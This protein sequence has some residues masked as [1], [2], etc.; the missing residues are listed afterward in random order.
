ML[1]FGQSWKTKWRKSLTKY[2]LKL[3][4]QRL[5]WVSDRSSWSKGKAWTGHVKA[6]EWKVNTLHPWQTKF[7]IGVQCLW[8]I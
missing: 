1:P 7:V 3:E 8:I 4:W 5:V 6:V 2:K